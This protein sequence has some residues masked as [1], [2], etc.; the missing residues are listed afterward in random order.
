MDAEKKNRIGIGAENYNIGRNR[1]ANKTRRSRMLIIKVGAHWYLHNGQA[2]RSI[3]GENSMSEPR[4]QLPAT[5][6]TDA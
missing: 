3:R 2:Y 1:R 5:K 4:Q 6:H